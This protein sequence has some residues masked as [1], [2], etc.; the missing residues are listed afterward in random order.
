M[1]IERDGTSFAAINQIVRDLSR[2]PDQGGYSAGDRAELRRYQPGDPLPPAAWRV[3]SDAAPSAWLETLPGAFRAKAEQALTLIAAITIE[4]GTPGGQPIGKALATIRYAEARFVRLLRAR[5]LR[6]VAN[7]ARPAARR[8]AAEGAGAAMI[9]GFS[10][11]GPF[12]LDAM[13]ESPFAAKRAHDIARDYFLTESR[14]YRAEQE[15]A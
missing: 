10:A 1:N 9:G 8:C 2:T 5:G 12:L 14:L 3:L 11:F 6:D 13:L 4:A 7:E 15:E